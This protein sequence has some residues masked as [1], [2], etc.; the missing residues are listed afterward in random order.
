MH[1]SAQ[2]IHLINVRMTHKTANVPLLEAV[3]FKDKGAALAEICGLAGVCECV[4]LQ[5]CNRV[6][7]Y[8]ASEDDVATAEA[9]RE[10]LACRAGGMAAEVFRATEISLNEEA[11]LHLLRV[12]CGLES[13]V[14]GEDQVINQ[15]WDA[16]LEAESAKTVG[17]V[18]KHI[19][20][21]VVNVGFGT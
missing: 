21:R 14:I 7:L 10:H 16:Y 4:L 11:L 19:F 20:N 12:T 13:M 17:A 5:T 18:L 9:V 8:I 1:S 6:E 15:V 3:A 2:T